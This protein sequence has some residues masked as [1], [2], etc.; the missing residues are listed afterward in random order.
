MPMPKLLSAAALL[1]VTS[2]YKSDFP[3]SILN[4]EVEGGMD[5]T[6]KMIKTNT[7]NNFFVI[8]P[9]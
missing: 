3:F 7:V 8:S 5:V 6:R 1:K 2:E 4:A 9:N